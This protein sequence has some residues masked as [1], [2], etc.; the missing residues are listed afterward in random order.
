MSTAEPDA[1]AKDMIAFTVFPALMPPI[2]KFV[3]PGKRYYLKAD[4]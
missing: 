3:R 4:A 2:D 1:E